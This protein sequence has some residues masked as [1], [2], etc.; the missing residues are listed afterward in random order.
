M[1]NIRPKFKS[2]FII[3]RMDGTTY[4]L[5]KMGIR[6]RSFDP[7]SPSYQHTFQ[8]VGKY[9][10]VLTDTKVSQLV[11][12]FVFDIYA[13]DNYD[14]ELQRMQ[15]SKVFESSEPFY[16]IN[17]R[18]PFLRWRVVADAFSVQR[19]DNYWKAS[20]ISVNLNCIDGYAQTIATTLDDIKNNG[21]KWGLELGSLKIKPLN[22]SLRMKLHLKYLT[23]R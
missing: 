15:V 14:Y 22:I 9:N 8:Q 18:I 23:H 12:P 7:P 3:Q 10:A 6:V 2:T 21:N 1:V 16:I 17:L 20:S 13:N 19:L 4:D 11:I 5:G